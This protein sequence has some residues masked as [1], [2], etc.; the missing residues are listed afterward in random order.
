MLALD[1]RP[2]ILVLTWTKEDLNKA[3]ETL[4]KQDLSIVREHTT[5]LRNGGLE[6]HLALF[7]VT[8][9]VDLAASIISKEN[10]TELPNAL[11][12]EQIS[13]TASS[14][15]LERSAGVRI[16]TVAPRWA[17]LAARRPRCRVPYCLDRSWI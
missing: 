14:V 1:A 4:T 13:T 10:L 15:A 6:L 12:L 9:S 16:A 11:N 2:T 5:S 3:R 7:D 17:Y 8:P